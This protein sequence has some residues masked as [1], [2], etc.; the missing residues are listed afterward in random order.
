MI[1]I[2]ADIKP[3]QLSYPSEFEITNEREEEEGGV[4]Q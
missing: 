4:R 2:I 3:L 1:S